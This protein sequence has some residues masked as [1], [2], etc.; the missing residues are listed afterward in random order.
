MILSA[1]RWDASSPLSATQVMQLFAERHIDISARTV[2]NWVQ[3]FGP[4]LAQAIQSHRRRWG[5][6]WDGDE[7]FCC[8]GQHKRYLYRASDQHGQGIA[9]LLRDKRDRA[10]AIAFFRRAL[11]QTG[12]SPH[13]LV[14]DH[15]RPSIKAVTTT[16]PAARHIRTGVHRARGETTK[17]IARSHIATRDH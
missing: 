15:H 8:R 17:P 16:A 11:R 1:V 10:S 9:M 2:L 3:T 14:S 5:R 6:R 7:V 13:T 12:M 4:Q